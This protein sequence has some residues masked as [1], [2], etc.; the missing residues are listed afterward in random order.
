VL[1][2][3]AEGFELGLWTDAAEE[4]EFGRVD[5]AGGEYDFFGASRF[6]GLVSKAS[7]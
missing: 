6:K 5:C 2:G 3:D 1:D 4:E 7:E